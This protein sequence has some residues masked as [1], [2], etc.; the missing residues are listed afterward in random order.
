L[1][2]EDDRLVFSYSTNDASSIVMSVTRPTI[3]TLFG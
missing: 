2:V 3:D 1:I